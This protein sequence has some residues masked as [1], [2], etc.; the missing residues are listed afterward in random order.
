[1]LETEGKK[2][3]FYFFDFFLKISGYLE[4]RGNELSYYGKKGLKFLN[5]NWVFIFLIF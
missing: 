5:K 2:G 1:M 4:E 3:Q